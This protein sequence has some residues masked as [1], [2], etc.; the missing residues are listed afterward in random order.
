MTTHPITPRI[1]APDDDADDAAHRA[2]RPTRGRRGID[3]AEL[4]RDARERGERAALHDALRAHGRRMCGEPPRRPTDADASDDTLA[5][6]VAPPTPMQTRTTIST[7][8]RRRPSARGGSTHRSSR[9]SRRSA[10]NRY[11]WWS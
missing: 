6:T 1:H 5:D 2:P 7:P 8:T 3:Y 11:A 9:S 10:P 4:V